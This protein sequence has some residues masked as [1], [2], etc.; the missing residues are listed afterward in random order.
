M[1]FQ[2]IIDELTIEEIGM[3]TEKL[4]KEY[5]KRVRRLSQEIANAQARL[6][7][8]QRIRQN[9]LDEQGK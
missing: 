9:L 3:F 7:D 1:D 8:L 2:T 6:G 4:N 5:D